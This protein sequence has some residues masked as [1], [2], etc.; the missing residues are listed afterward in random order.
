MSPRT[1][2]RLLVALAALVLLPIFVTPLWSIR[3]VAPQY[4]EGMGMNIGVSEVRGHDEHDIQNINILNHYIG[5]QAIDPEG[6]PELDIFPPVLMGIIALGLVAAAIGRRWALTAW[7]VLFVGLS[8][9][10][11][12]DFYLW[13]LD[14]GHNLDPMAAIKVPGMTYTPPL[15]GSK[16]LL[17]ITASS[18]PH[19]GS[20]F[21][22]LSMGLAAWGVWIAWRQPKGRPIGRVAVV[23][24]AALAL[25]LAACGGPDATPARDAGEGASASGPLMAYGESDDPY[26]G[27]RVEKIR[28]GGEIETAAGERLRF[29]SVECLAGFLAEGRIPRDEVAAVRV[30]DFPHGSLLIPAETARYIHTPLLASPARRGLNVMAASTEKLA[31]SL[32]DAYAGRLL[33]WDDVLDLAASGQP[34]S[35]QAARP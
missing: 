2:S 34:A 8:V 19:I 23:P 25:V 29:K 4:P 9:A 6:I 11:F 16:T 35:A 13:M 21:L 10:A 15:I 30:V 20:G 27:G 3:L 31:V 24:V 7:L 28:W 22:T 26:C 18:W 1:K 14:Y 5:M 17:N 12:A 32:Q 33:S